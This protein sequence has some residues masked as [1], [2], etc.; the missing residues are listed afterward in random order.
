M[1]VSLGIPQGLTRSS[2]QASAAA[3]L[4]FVVL[5]AGPAEGASPLVFF[6]GAGR[7]RVAVSGHGELSRHAPN[8][9]EDVALG[10]DGV[11]EGR[12]VSGEGGGPRET[13]AGLPVTLFEGG[14]PVARTTSDVDGR[15][16]VRNLRG[17]L[18]RVVIDTADGPRWR[19][20]RLWTSSAAP[21]H[22]QSEVSVPV[23]RW[24]LRGQSP[25]PADGFPPGATVG[26]IAAGAIAIPIIYHNVKKDNFVPASP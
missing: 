24:L 19:F 25:F 5:G 21:P 7:G 22:A 15:F 9:I 14:L 1:N 8:A 13:V 3:W 16:A 2:H 11:L 18:Y 17:G 26:A 6:Q 4:C 20:C 10:P 23:G 12:A